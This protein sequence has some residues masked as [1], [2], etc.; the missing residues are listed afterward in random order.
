MHQASRKTF[1]IVI[2]VRYALSQNAE[3]RRRLDEHRMWG[4]RDLIDIPAIVSKHGGILSKSLAFNS[5]QSHT[6]LP[7]SV[8]DVSALLGRRF[9]KFSTLVISLGQAPI[10]EG[11]KS[12]DI[13]VLLSTI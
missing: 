4:V 11:S 7:R 1:V 12:K 6:N 13:S 8:G 10:I 9:R 2:V 5:I 3:H